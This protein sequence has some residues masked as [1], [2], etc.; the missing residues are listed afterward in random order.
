M[1]DVVVFFLYIP[2]VLCRVV[3]FS[4]LALA[5]SL[6]LSMC[7]W[8][9]FATQLTLDRAANGGRAR[10]CTR[11]VHVDRIR[12]YFPVIDPDIIDLFVYVRRAIGSAA[13]YTVD[14]PSWYSGR[15]ITGHSLSAPLGSP[16][17]LIRLTRFVS[18]DGCRGATCIVLFQ[19]RQL[20]MSACNSIV[21]ARR[22]GDAPRTS[23]TTFLS[24]ARKYFVPQSHHSLLANR[25]P[26][27]TAV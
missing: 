5:L 20:L 15:R 16:S 26:R 9:L 1:A 2:S 19:L 23:A 7:L 4:D 24:A 13:R 17:A 21:Q 14:A 18:T 22:W 25:S 6:R 11:V 8:H 27:V 10:L 12:H 3:T